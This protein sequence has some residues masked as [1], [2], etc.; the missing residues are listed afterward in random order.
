VGNR[1]LETVK[2]FI[3]DM[4]ARLVHRVQLTTDGQRQ[5]LQAVDGAFGSDIDYV[6][7]L[8]IYGEIT[9]EGQ[10][11]YSPV[12]CIGCKSEIIMGNPDEKHIVTSYF[13][14]LNLT[15]RMSMR[16]FTRCAG[17]LG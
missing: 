15:M 10:R 12:E 3:S 9:P 14:R 1:D 16:R 17:S 11:K 6:M 8:K 13:E 7:L 5:Y 4:A 2:I